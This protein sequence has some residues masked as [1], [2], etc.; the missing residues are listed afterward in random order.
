MKRALNLVLV[1]LVSIGITG[2]GNS[3]TKTNTQETKQV[4]QSKKAPKSVV[5]KTEKNT[6][7]T[8]A[9]IYAKKVDIDDARDITKHVTA[10]VFMSD[11]LTPG[12][13]VQHVLNQSY[14]FL[15]QANLKGTDTVT[16]GVMKG[17]IR[18]FQYTVTMKKFV[19]NDSIAM[20]DV[21]LKASKVEK[22]SPQVEEFAKALGWTILK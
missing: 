13:A 3:T 5:A 18:V 20:S 10:T 19:L 12:L 2:C 6:I 22:M 9:F 21:V 8:D 17:D 1:A 14:D 7:K 16:I 11:E 4:E 15:Q